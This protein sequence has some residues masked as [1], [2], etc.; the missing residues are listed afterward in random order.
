MK[1]LTKNDLI[2]FAK[3]VLEKVDYPFE[4]TNLQELAE[5]YVNEKLTVEK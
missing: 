2:E 3:Q 4:I 1:N 5:K